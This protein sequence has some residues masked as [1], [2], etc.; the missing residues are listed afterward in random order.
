MK[1]AT[2][3][4]ARFIGC[5]LTELARGWGPFLGPLERAEWELVDLIDDLRVRARRGFE[6]GQRHPLR[7]FQIGVEVLVEFAGVDARQKPEERAHVARRRG[8]TRIEIHR[9]AE[10]LE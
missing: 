7:R 3:K 4:T 6:P 2:M 9:R 10:E 1:S 5:P 8:R